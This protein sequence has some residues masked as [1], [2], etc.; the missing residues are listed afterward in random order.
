MGQLRG[1]RLPAPWDGGGQARASGG[2]GLS[3]GWGPRFL[4]ASGLDSQ[5]RAVA[6]EQKSWLGAVAW[7]CAAVA[8]AAERSID[9]RGAAK[10]GRGFGILS[11]L[12]DDV[13]RKSSFKVGGRK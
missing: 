9:E 5:A 7:R 8:R 1:H 11:Q 4:R 10:V 6:V 3:G 2:G 12:I 13:C